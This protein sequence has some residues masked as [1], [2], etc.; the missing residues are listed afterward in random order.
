MP[1]WH[2]AAPWFDLSVLYWALYL[3]FDTMEIFNLGLKDQTG[4]RSNTD[5]EQRLYKVGKW[6]WREEKEDNNEGDSKNIE[7]HVSPA[8]P[9]MDDFQYL[10]RLR[11]SPYLAAAHTKFADSLLTH[12]R[13]WWWE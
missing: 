8:N 6:G 12:W 2:A 4:G 13:D 9:R 5:D 10:F 1:D 3:Q 11:Q 7:E